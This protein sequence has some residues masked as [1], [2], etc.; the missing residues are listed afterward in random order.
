MREELIF[1]TILDILDLVGVFF[2]VS[3]SNHIRPNE[4]A[5]F[6]EVGAKFFTI[7]SEG[8][9]KAMVIVQ[10]LIKAKENHIEQIRERQGPVRTSACKAYVIESNRG[11][12]SFTERYQ[13][14]ASLRCLNKALVQSISPA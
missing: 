7:Y 13:T 4:S 8:H 11:R 2:F 9:S 1:L 6:D 12:K 10:H 5:G 14:Y 3:K